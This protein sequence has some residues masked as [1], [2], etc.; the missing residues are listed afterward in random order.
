[1]PV[2]PRVI[3]VVLDGPG[4][5]ALPDAGLYGD[6]GSDTPGHVPLLVTGAR[7]RRG[8]GL[9]AR[10]TCADPGQTIAANFGIAPLAR[11]VSFLEEI[12]VEHS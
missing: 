3:V 2:F 1:M 8:R 9:G 4:C 12:V 5:G 11:G 10:A 7:V 6:E